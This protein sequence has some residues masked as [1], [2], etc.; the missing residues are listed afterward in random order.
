MIR[1]ADK[2]DSSDI[3]ALAK[4]TSLFHEE[5]L[6]ELEGML[7]QYFNGQL[8]DDHQWLVFE[9]AGIQAA[10]YYAAEM[11]ADKVWNLYFIGV[12]PKLQGQ[13]LG[14]KLLTFVE[15]TLKEQ[16]ERMLIVETSGLEN[17]TLTRK[18]YLKHGYDEEAR[19]RDYY[20][21]YDD[22]VIFRKLL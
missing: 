14:G 18:F 20:Q 22:K 11:M 4:A 7:S 17:F 6:L 21:Q 8:S 3:L 5:E 2:S 12:S 15:N 10:A 9:N 1:I 19:I 13:G 16:Q